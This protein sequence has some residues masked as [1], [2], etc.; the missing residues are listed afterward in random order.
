LISVKETSPG[1]ESRRL[2]YRLIVPRVPPADDACLPDP[3]KPR[4]IVPESKE[5][6]ELRR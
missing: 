4:N 5:L 6:N 1:A 2:P 3:K